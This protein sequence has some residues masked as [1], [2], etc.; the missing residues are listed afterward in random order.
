MVRG[1][2]QSS[3]AFVTFS[4][5][6]I[7]GTDNG[8]DTGVLISSVLSTYLRRTGLGSLLNDAEAIEDHL[9]VSPGLDLT[10][11]TDGFLL[12]MQRA[13]EPPAPSEKTLN[14]SDESL[15][16]MLE[17]AEVAEPPGSSHTASGTPS[18]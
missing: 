15:Q 13:V 10:I 8:K 5:K 11:N 3:L 4:G 6:A 14:N 9:Q 17:L 2:K 7:I 18:T 1:L 12:S 16:E